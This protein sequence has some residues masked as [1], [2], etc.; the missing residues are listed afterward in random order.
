M[1]R[2]PSKDKSLKSFCWEITGPQ[3]AESW[4]WMLSLTGQGQSKQ[5]DVSREACEALT[6]LVWKTIWRF[7]T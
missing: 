1:G 2:D 7:N 3:T 5:M 4:Q 6:L